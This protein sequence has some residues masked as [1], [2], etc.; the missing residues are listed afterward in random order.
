MRYIVLESGVGRA[1]AVERSEWL[2]SSLSD[3]I[4]SRIHDNPF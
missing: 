2:H 4:V 3:L 1:L